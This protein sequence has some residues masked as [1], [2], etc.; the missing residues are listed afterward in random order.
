[1]RNW[2]DSNLAQKA[3]QK[4]GREITALAPIARLQ[5]WPSQTDHTLEA[6]FLHAGNADCTALEINP[7]TI[8]EA[9]S[10]PSIKPATGWLASQI[11]R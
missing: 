2:E 1:M 6:C 4:L 5:F 10:L 3:H 11:L 8:E 9:V 7:G